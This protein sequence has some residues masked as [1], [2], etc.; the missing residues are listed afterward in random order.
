MCIRDSKCTKKAGDA[1]KQMLDFD[2]IEAKTAA[3]LDLDENFY[4]DQDYDLEDIDR[5]GYGGFD[6]GG[7]GNPYTEDMY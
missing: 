6:E 1:P 3:N 4:G 7:G 2:E 5:D